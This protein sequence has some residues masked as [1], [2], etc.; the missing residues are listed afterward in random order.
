M[1]EFSA[2]IA[3]AA[4][5]HGL[6]A[7]LVAAIVRIESSG[8]PLAWNPE[9]RYH[10]LWDVRLRQPFRSLT[11]AEVASEVPPPDFP[12]LVGDPDQEWW[13]QQASWGLMQLMGAVAREL[14]CRAPY[15]TALCAYP[16][17]N[18]DL[19]CRKLAQL[20]TWTK[21]HVARA[22]AAYNAGPGGVASVAGRRYA[23][24]VVVARDQIRREGHA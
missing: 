15:L 4:V 21:G 10:Y 11:P 2:S 12:A 17:A 19:G 7:D 6:D 23:T 8:D 9:P 1:T 18:L 14:D 3:A 5:R 13:A 24:K 20:L 22:C 16:D